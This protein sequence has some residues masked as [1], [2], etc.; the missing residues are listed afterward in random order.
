MLSEV[1]FYSVYVQAP[2]K[3]ASSEVVIQGT[4]AFC[5]AMYLKIKKAN[6]YYPFVFNKTNLIFED[7]KSNFRNILHHLADILFESA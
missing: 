5:A 7:L 2:G 6:R 4:F 3:A 1:Y